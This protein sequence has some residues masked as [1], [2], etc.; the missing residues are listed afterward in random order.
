MIVKKINENKMEVRS[1]LMGTCYIYKFL[2]DYPKAWGNYPDKPWFFQGTFYESMEQAVNS[3]Q[4]KE[5]SWE[6]STEE[7]KEI[8]WDTMI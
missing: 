3:L 7:E 6:K 4:E 8:I 5:N 2:V 1:N